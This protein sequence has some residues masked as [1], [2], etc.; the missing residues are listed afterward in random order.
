MKNLSKVL[1][2]LLACL[3]LL[4]S[5][6]AFAAEVPEGYPDVQIDPATG[7]PYDFGGIEIWVMDWWSPK[8]GS[9]RE[10]T[11]TFTQDTYDYQDWLM[12]TYN[13]TLKVGSVG[14]WTSNPEDL[15]NYCNEENPDKLCMFIMRPECVSAPAKSGLLTPLD[16][17]DVDFEGDVFNPYTYQLNAVNGHY[18]GFSVGKA[19]IRGILFFNKRLVADAGIDPEELYAMVE[20]GT[21]NWEAFDKVL[22]ACQ[23]D[24][25]SDGVYDIYGMASSQVDLYQCLV[26]SNGGRIFNRADDGSLSIGA[27]DS[28]VVDALNF[29]IDLLNKYQMPD[30]T[31]GSQWNWYFDAFRNGEAAFCFYQGYMMTPGNAFYDMEDE[32]GV[33]PAPIGNGEGAAYG[34]VQNENTIVIPGN[35]DRETANKMAIAYEMWC[36]P[37][38]GYEDEDD[39]WKTDWYDYLY[40]DESVDITLAVLRDN[41]CPDYT[42][43]VGSTNDVLG[44]DFYWSMQW[45]TAEA[46]IE[47]K[48]P[49]WQ[50]LID[51]YNA[52][53]KG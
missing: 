27:Q 29:G 25:D 35:I 48:S 3:M 42:V 1:A 15:L 5:V 40:D 49:V 37:T 19:E 17:L 51:E 9:R 44:A 2:M 34:H 8:D 43:L 20:E 31:E 14:D 46:M 18:Y 45:S 36:Q 24:K 53:L 30:P 16:E 4:A 26:A 28:R 41:A 38:P 12:E 47:G 22:A 23:V 11:N 33:L 10:A 13:F 21:W 6:T 7:E 50:S 32:F 39:A 52:A